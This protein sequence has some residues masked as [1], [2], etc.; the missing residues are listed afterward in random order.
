MSWYTFMPKLFNMSLTASVAICFVLLLRLFLKKAPKVISYALWGIVLFRLLFPVSIESGL[1]LYNLFN[2]PTAESGTMTNVIEYVPENIVHTEYPSVTLP[3]PGISNVINEA[4]PQGEEQLVA[5]PLEAPMSLATYI[6]MVGVLVM[7]ICSIVSYMKL[8][9]KLLASVKLRENIFIADDINTPFVMGLIRP[10]IYLPS[11]LSEKE[12]DYIILHERHHIRRGDHVIK[13]LSFIALCLHCFNPLVWIAFI[14]SGKDMEMSCDEAVLRKLGAEI[15]VDYSASLI[16]LATGRRIIAG[17]PLAFGEGNTEGRI[18]N[19]AK[20]KKPSVWVIVIAVLVCVL[21][22]VCLI[23][24]PLNRGTDLGTDPE[25]LLLGAEYRAAEILYHTNESYDYTD[26]DSPSICI[27][28]DY[29]FYVRNAEGNWDFVGQMEPYTLDTKELAEYTAY[30]DGWLRH[31]SPGEITDSY[32]MRLNE[33]EYEAQLYLAFKTKKGDT[34]LGVGVE[35]ISERGEGPSDDTA[36]M[37]LVRLESTFGGSK[38]VGEFH[39]RSLAQ[40]VGR[41]VEI[42]HTHFNGQH[43]HFMIVG[44]RVF[45]APYEDGVQLP[46]SESTD[47]GFAVFYQNKEKSGYR[48]REYHVYEDAALAENGIFLAPHPAIVNF[49]GEPVPGETYDVILLNNK[50]IEKA[51]RVWLYTDERTKTESQPFLNGNEMLLFSHKNNK[52]NC[53]IRQYFYDEEGT[54]IAETEQLLPAPMIPTSANI[55]G[56]FD[57]YLYV[58][59]DGANYRFERTDETPSLFTKDSCIYSFTEKTVPDDVVWKVYSV[60]ESPERR[61]LIAEAGAYYGQVYRYSMAK[62]VSE[63][64]LEAAKSAGKITMENG[65]AISGQKQWETFYKNTQA[66]KSASVKI[67]CYYTLSDPKQ[68]DET[69]Y[70]VYKEDYPA[71]YEYDLRF[72]DGVYTLTWDE[73]GTGHVRQYRYLRKFEGITGSAYSSKEPQYAT[74]YVLTNNDN[75]SWDELWR[76]HLSGARPEDPIDFFPIYCEDK[77]QQLPAALS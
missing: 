11:S 21:L 40:S 32:I 66:G 30:K 22:A 65:T 41:D 57:A 7:V 61:I 20:W 18:K 69:Y 68:Y 26:N 25:D 28:A 9:G 74:Q 16:S 63:D 48:L 17:T 62:A 72:E 44:F 43:P 2:V 50:K 29:C 27:T 71:L 49:S 1:S 46:S 31:F 14:L 60:K 36:L 70:E 33:T 6:W 56:A 37:F 45:E 42:F 35:D 38:I 59:I 8:H 39:E 53:R 12:R 55:S 24:N 51:T 47:M 73:S 75:A 34:L 13:L 4:L 76:S 64:L 58:P 77:T 5:D 23:T 10:K 52:E 54:V 67:V 19:I 3:V 15:R